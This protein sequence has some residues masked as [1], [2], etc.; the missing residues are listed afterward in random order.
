MDSNTLLNFTAPL[1]ENSI[2]QT[3]LNLQL[4]DAAGLGDIPSM[5]KL[6]EEGAQINGFAR[7][8]TAL[9]SAASKGRL[10]A[11]QFLLT[12]GAGLDIVS[13]QIKNTAL[14]CAV[15]D[16]QTEVVNFLISSGARLDCQNVYGSTAFMLAFRHENKNNAFNILCAMPMQNIIEIHETNRFDDVVQP[17][18]EFIIANQKKLLELFTVFEE[19]QSSVKGLFLA[20][21]IELMA[22][23]FYEAELF[24]LPYVFRLIEDIGYVLN[25]NT[26]MTFLPLEDK[27]QKRKAQDTLESENPKVQKT[28]LPLAQGTKRKPQEEL[29]NNRVKY[30]KNEQ[31]ETNTTDLNNQNKPGK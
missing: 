15:I 10:E 21:P 25:N 1:I 22:K 4:I 20:L 30:Q 14:I 9:M 16:R 13:T 8:I 7:H 11:V 5:S 18:K 29:V 26:T 27:G 23:I 31:G 12:K 17:C 24:E 2:K 3:Q 19:N 6:L 28:F